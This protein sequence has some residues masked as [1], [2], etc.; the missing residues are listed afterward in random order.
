MILS[1]VVP[2]FNRCE[3]LVHLLRDLKSQVLLLKAESLVEI[4]VCDDASTDET[5]LEVSR[6][7]EGTEFISYLKYEVNIGLEKNLI[8]STRHA[9]GEYLWIFG[10]DD[11][12]EHGAAL[13]K[14]LSILQNKKSDLFILNRTRRSFS[15]EKLISE[16][17]MRISSRGNKDYDGVGA[18]FQEW[19]FISIIGFITVNIMRRQYFLD[20]YDE[21]YFGT[22]YPQLGMMTD[23]FSNAKV[24]L[25]SEPLVCHRTQTAE[26]KA[27]AF[28]GKDKE[29]VFMS[30]VEMRDAMYFGA[31]YIR[32]INILVEK[33]AL[34]YDE[35]NTINEN[36]VINGRLVDFLFNN[37]V[38]AVNFGAEITDIDQTHI[39]DFFTHVDLSSDQIH[40]L[41]RYSFM[42]DSK[43]C[44]QQDNKESLTISVITP[45]YNQV[46]FFH[47]CLDSVFEQTHQP[48]E[49]IV[50]DPGSNDGSLNVA[51]YYKNVTLLNEPD[52]GQ[53]DAVAKGISLA[54]GDVIAWVNSDDSYFDN[55]VFSTIA[56]EFKTEDEVIYGNGIFMAGDGSK[57][58]D[59]YINKDPSTLPWRFQQEDGILQP[60]LF[61]RR[62]IVDKIGLPSKYLEFCMDYEYW[63]RAMKAGV[64][65]SHIDKNFAKAYFHIDNKTYGQRGSS[66]QQVCEMQFEQ[67]G[68]VNHIWLKRYAEY[69][70][71]GFDG[72]IA[73]SSNS[74]VKDEGLVIDSYVELLRDY[75]TSFNVIALLES[76]SEEK[77]Y[78][79][80]LKELRA[81][82][83]IPSHYQLIKPNSE[84]IDGYVDYD[85]GGRS[86]R[87]DAAWKDSQIKNSHS[88]LS[89]VI[90]ARESDTCII[91]CNGPSLNNIDKGL[92]DNA[93]VIASNNIFLSDEVIKHVDYYTCVNYLVAE[94][95]AP[96]INQLGIPKILPWWLAYCINSG[97]DT[98]FVDAK[99]LPEFSKD[100]FSNMSWRHT[101][102]FFNMHLAYG[103]GYKKVLLVGCDHS[104][105]QPGGIKEQELIHSSDDDINHF[106]PRYFKSKK[107][108]AADVDEMEAMYSLAKDVFES[109]GREIINCTEGGALK[110]FRCSTL[111]KEI[112]DVNVSK[113]KNILKPVLVG[114]YSREDLVHF[115]ETD[116]VAA[117]VGEKNTGFMIDVGAHHGYASSPFLDKGWEVLG[118]EP[119]PNNRAILRQRLGG[120][121]RLKIIEDAVSNVAGETVSFYASDESTGVSGLS[122]FTE[123]HK[124]ICEVKTTT[125]DDQISINNIE[126]IDFLK[127]DTEGF[128]LMVLKGFPWDSHQPH[129]IECE[130]ENSKTEP[131]GY[132]FEDIAN[133]LVERDYYVYVSEWHPIVRYGIRHDWKMLSSYPCSL[134]TDT[135]WGN[136]LAFKVKP[137]EKILADHLYRLAG[138]SP[139]VDDTQSAQVEPKNI[140]RMNRVNA[141]ISALLS[142]HPKLHA[143]AV[144]VA[145]KLK[146]L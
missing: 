22:M 114:P 107:W 1:I 117:Y 25:I 102:T 122:G 46:Q 90:K 39:N 124:K 42:T 128:D 146:S 48:L 84:E 94:A 26:E 100:I 142:P 104:Y 36:T 21:R 29:K 89:S 5:E 127:I 141:K 9:S 51:R 12:L 61:F 13:E 111:E 68:Y 38:K 50:L 138:L 123:K 143:L 126:A 118:F 87:F 70:I 19:G 28:K 17:W 24:T 34:S 3:E 67:F 131:L 45:S 112:G 81:Y 136:L 145:G 23:A 6:V 132:L 62:S 129:I 144:R 99:G 76:K 37:I 11:F 137:D 80:T 64:N 134:S 31:P 98:H 2:T 53:G 16:D 71:E 32:M 110:L 130:F 82:E 18:F 59:V 33:G 106:D 85:M 120:H 139:S 44:R 78:G 41:S 83:L 116:L 125:L 47:E 140:T 30:D 79:D 49:H 115:D 95:S 105:K 10:D 43:F 93:D 92:F 133:F 72:V 135:A 65:F 8:E 57:I 60:A 88:F 77:G 55:E 96:Q 20:A 7:Q 121:P 75:N 58:R 52:E 108:Q 69:L 109:E 56:D 35:I 119:D 15:L 27:Q 103:L 86:W 97:E 14:I 4:I 40:Q 73:H 91:V 113:I 101:V 54:K 66:Y 74:S 63:I